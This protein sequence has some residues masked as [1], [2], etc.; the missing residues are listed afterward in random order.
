MTGSAG[1]ISG[2]SAGPVISEPLRTRTRMIVK[3]RSL[4]FGAADHCAV[5]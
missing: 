2:P 1:L 3:M 4:Y 5:T